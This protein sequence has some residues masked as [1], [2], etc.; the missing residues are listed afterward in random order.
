MTTIGKKLRRT[1]ILEPRHRVVQP[2]APRQA[3]RMSDTKRAAPPLSIGINFP[4]DDCQDMAH[5]SAERFQSCLT[6]VL[7]IML[8]QGRAAS[9]PVPNA[10]SSAARAP[11]EAVESPKI[12]DPVID[13]KPRAISSRVSLGE[14]VS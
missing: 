13:E 4:I 14:K 10:I 5:L 3:D 1:S 11:G 7:R 12:L 6:Q 2:L 8:E 9:H